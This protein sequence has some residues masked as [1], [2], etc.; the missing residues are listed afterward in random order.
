VRDDCNAPELS[1]KETNPSFVEQL[2]LLPNI[3]DEADE[4]DEAE[5]KLARDGGKT[6]AEV[7]RGMRMVSASRRSSRIN[8]R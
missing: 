8:Q 6:R 5:E 3:F 1:R 2:I 4:E 7:G